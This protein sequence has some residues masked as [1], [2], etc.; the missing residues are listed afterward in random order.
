M[1]CFHNPKTILLFVPFFPGTQWLQCCKRP[2][3][4]ERPLAPV[5][6]GTQSRSDLP[7]RAVI[8]LSLSPSHWDTQGRRNQK[9]KMGYILWHSTRSEAA[10]SHG[11]V[12]SQAAFEDVFAQN[13]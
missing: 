9:R 3:P 8:L 10:T 12:S 1:I 4:Q 13:L 6:P 5:I 7:H 11:P 2:I